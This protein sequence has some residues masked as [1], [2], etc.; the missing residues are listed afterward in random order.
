MKRLFMDKKPG[1]VKFV[2][3]YP[4]NIGLSSD[5]YYMVRLSDVEDAIALVKTSDKEGIQV[6]NKGLVQRDRGAGKDPVLEEIKGNAKTTQ[7]TAVFEG[8][9]VLHVVAGEV[10]RVTHPWFFS[11]IQIIFAVEDVYAV[12]GNS[13]SSIEALRLVYKFFNKFLLAYRHSSGEIRNR[14][15]TEENDISLYMLL[16]ISEFSE[17]EKKMGSID[18]LAKM[19]I[20]ETMDNRKFYPYPMRGDATQEDDIP[21][22]KGRHISLT[23]T[24]AKKPKITVEQLKSFMQASGGFYE[25]SPYRSMLLSGLERIGLDTD[26]NA[27]IINFDTAVEMTIA[28]FITKML[29]EEGMSAEA[30]EDLFDE[31][32]ANSRALRPKDY[33]TTESRVSRF[34]ESLNKMRT[35]KQL[36][37]IKIRD[38]EEYKKWKSDV[39]VKRNKIV[40]AGKQFGEADA[41]SAFSA[42]Q[43]LVLFIEKISLET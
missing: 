35:G 33:L 17:E 12:L 25:V 22:I 16:Y 3:D 6:Y 14:F 5:F 18:I 7:L 8:G 15:L 34:E 38:T 11:E 37:K 36:A 27:S 10:G 9:S 29:K 43:K 28:F 30:I 13:E 42:S 39:R 31:T 20:K 4:F 26:Y 21:L 1:L 24:D 40:H 23:M 41:K 2:F 32:I 19:P